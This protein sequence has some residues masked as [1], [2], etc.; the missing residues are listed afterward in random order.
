[1]KEWG[2]KWNLLVF[3]DEGGGCRKYVEFLVCTDEGVRK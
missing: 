1:M 3:T 2:S